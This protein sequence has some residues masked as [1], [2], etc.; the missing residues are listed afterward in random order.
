MAACWLWSCFVLCFV[1]GHTILRDHSRQQSGSALCKL[2]ACII[3]PAPTTI[4]YSTGLRFSSFTTMEK[5]P[6]LLVSCEVG[7]E[8]SIYFITEFFLCEA[9]M[10]TLSRSLAQTVH[11]PSPG[12]PVSAMSLSSLGFNLSS[13]RV[14]VLSTWTLG[15]EDFNNEND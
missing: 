9:L 12:D 3:S 15:V 7:T 10:D 8:G 1:W 11:L 2:S 6:C 4:L 5:Q 13:S 14:S